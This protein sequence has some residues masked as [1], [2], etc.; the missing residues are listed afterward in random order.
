[1]SKKKE[2]KLS[3]YIKVPIKMLVKARDLYIRSMNQWSSH[4]LIGSGMGL[5]IPVCNVSTLPRSFSASH[6]QYSKRP[7]DDR[8][9]ELVRAAS[10]RNMIIGDAR[11]GPSKLRKAKSSRSCGGH[12]GFEKIDETSP[13]ISFGS[14]HKML[15]KSKSYGVAKYTYSLQ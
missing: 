11:H 9:P 10:A 6:A 7:E 13:L 8:V 12:H 1:M 5:G 15:Q 2:T 14:K 3:K 4:D